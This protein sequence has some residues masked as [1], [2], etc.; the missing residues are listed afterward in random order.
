MTEP[1]TCPFGASR[2]RKQKAARYERQGSP[3]KGL[4]YATILADAYHGGMRGP[5]KERC[6]RRKA[7]GVGWIQGP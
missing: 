3:A 5:P 2:T 1:T 7:A 4:I 6:S